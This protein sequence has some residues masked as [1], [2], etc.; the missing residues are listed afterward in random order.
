MELD[1]SKGLCGGVDVQ[2]I[3][4]NTEKEKLWEWLAL[5]DIKTY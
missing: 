1:K 5:Q 2:N 4:E 3:W